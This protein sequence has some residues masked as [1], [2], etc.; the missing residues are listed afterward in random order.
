MKRYK[1]VIIA[2]FGV[3]TACGSMVILLRAGFIFNEWIKTN[4]AT[5][6]LD[7][8]ILGTGGLIVFGAGYSLTFAGTLKYRKT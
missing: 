2:S 5:S 3:I 1:G 8:F 4:H 6:W 7:W